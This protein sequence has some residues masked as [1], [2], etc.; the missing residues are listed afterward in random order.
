MKALTSYGWP[1]NVRELENEVKRAA[2]LTSRRM[3]DVS[4]FSDS[5]REERLETAV[6]VS[7]SPNSKQS[8]KDQVTL[9][10]I[11]MIRDAMTQTSADKRRTA[12]MLGLSHQGLLNKLK[13]YGLES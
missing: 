4:D 1:G 3:I 8:L 10:E 7:K 5:L 13:R 2:V 11:Q 9:L 6:S 12:K